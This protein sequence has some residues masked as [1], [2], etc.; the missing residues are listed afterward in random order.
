MT[1]TT[2][3]DGLTITVDYKTSILTFDWDD[4]THPQWNFLHDLGED[5]IRK[6]LMNYCTQLLSEDETEDLHDD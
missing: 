4:E 5:G 2:E 1:E 3:R 6:A